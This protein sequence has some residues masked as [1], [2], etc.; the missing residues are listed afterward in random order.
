MND[1]LDNTW[2]STTDALKRTGMHHALAG[3]ALEPSTDG[4]LNIFLGRGAPARELAVQHVDTQRV[5]AWAAEWARLAFPTVQLSHKYAAALMCTAVPPVDDADIVPPWPYFLVHV[6]SG[7]LT[8]LASDG[9]PIEIDRIS[10]IYHREHWSIHAI[11][12]D[13]MLSMPWKHTSFMRDASAVREHVEGAVFDEHQ[14][15]LM[16]HDERALVV[17]GR[18]LL[19]ICLAFSDPGNVRMIGKGHAPRA[20]LSTQRPPNLTSR[21]F[22]LGAPVKVDCRQYV[23]SYIAGDRAGL[24]VRMLVRGF[25][26]NQPHGPGQSL[27]RRQ[28]IEP[29]WKGDIGA[30][31]LTRDHELLRNRR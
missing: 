20:P 30:P 25:W 26:R 4:Q 9:R 22:E 12:T 17:I 24:S 11:T 27:R 28:W 7:L 15:A 29:Y 2:W 14:Q 31:I 3:V 8:I 21:M 13:I 23:R 6:P 1:D 5:C 16:K 19:N 10:C 18:L